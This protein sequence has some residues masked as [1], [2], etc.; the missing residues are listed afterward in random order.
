MT[1]VIRGNIQKV[2]DWILKNGLEEYAENSFIYGD[3]VEYIMTKSDLVDEAIYKTDFA[4]IEDIEPAD[5]LWA[6][7]LEMD[8]TQLE[9]QMESRAETIRG[10]V[11]SFNGYVDIMS[12]ANTIKMMA[13]QASKL[14]F[15]GEM[16]Y[17]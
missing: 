11:F 6:E 10:A 17:E 12:T 8:I 14:T 4:R 9:E 16:L 1:I 5:I 15:E 2:Y 13:E 3:Y 7:I